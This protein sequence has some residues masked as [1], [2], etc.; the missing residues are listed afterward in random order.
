MMAR[1]AMSG[2]SCGDQPAFARIHMLVGLRAEAGHL[3][4]IPG[5]HAIIAGSHRMRAIL[6]HD[7]A[8]ARAEFGDRRHVGDMT[9]HVRQH[10]KASTAGSSLGV[11]IGEVDVIVPS[12]ST[13]TGTPPAL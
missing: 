2:S 11:E 3:A 12:I 13:N 7:D 1:A 4:E 5:A 9:A 10:Q 8:A 6:D